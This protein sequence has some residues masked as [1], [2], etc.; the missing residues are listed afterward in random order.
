MKQL[1]D[2]AAGRTSVD[3]LIINCK[4]V[5]V[6]NQTVMDGPLALGNG[7]VIGFGEYEAKEIID[8]EGGVIIPG[9]IDS[10]VHIESSSITPP[11]FSRV[12]LPHG[13]TTIIADPH[14]IANVCGL[15][16]IR[17]ML[18]SSKD[19]PL[20]VNVMLPSCVP[21]TPFEEAGAKL[22]ANDLAELINHPN[23]LGVGEVMDFPSVINAMTICWQK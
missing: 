14:E 2:M 10:H 1:I 12:V 11:Q 22:L 7:K 20:N 21:A 9:L 13:T 17:F 18:D 19:L 5:D 4:V 8:A 16:G 6:F 15:D 23:V 3:T